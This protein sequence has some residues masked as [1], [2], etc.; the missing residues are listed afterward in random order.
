MGEDCKAEVERGQHRAPNSVPCPSL[1]SGYADSG[2]AHSD[3][4]D[5]DDAAIADYVARLQQNTKQ[6]AP[7]KRRGP[8]PGARALYLL[9]RRCGASARQIHREVTGKSLPGRRQKLLKYTAPLRTMRTAHAIVNSP[10]S[11]PAALPL[12][13]PRKSASVVTAEISPL[14]LEIKARR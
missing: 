14:E 13:S 6:R 12:R 8:I 1:A 3:D 4:V 11:R 7:G 9:T 10:A 5:A 2:D